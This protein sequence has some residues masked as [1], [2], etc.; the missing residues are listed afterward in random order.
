M[1]TAFPMKFGAELTDDGTRFRLWAPKADRVR[2]RLEGCSRDL[3]LKHLADGW[4]GLLFP[5]RVSGRLYSFVLPD[6]TEVPDPASRF[7]PQDLH[8]PSEVINPRDF[9]WTARSW[10]GVPWHDAVLYELH[11][12]TFTEEGTFAA[13][14][15]RLDYLRDLG[16]T[17]IELMPVADFPGRRNWGYDGALLFAPD[18]VYGRPEALKALVNEAHL[19]GLMVILDV[20]YNH[21][22]PDGNYLGLYAPFFN[23][24]HPTPWGGAIN[25]D[26]P[27][28]R[29]FMIA[30][31]LFWLTEYRFDGLRLDAVHAIHDES[32]EHILETM[33]K[34]IHQ[35]LPERQ[36]HLILENEENDSALLDRGADGKPLLYTAQWNDDV[37]HTLHTAVTDESGGYYADYAGD[38]TKLA[39]SLAEGFAFQGEMMDYR[40]A[41]RGKPAK[42]LPPTAFVA[43]IQNHDQVGNR[44]FGDRLSTLCA[45]APLRA[46]AAIYLL[47]PQIPMIFM[48]EE[49]GCRQPFPFFC[50]FAGELAEAVREG[51]RKEF[52]RFPDFR[53]EAQ[54]ERIPDPNALK[55][56]EAAKLDWNASR[57]P[58][59][60]HWH[61]FYRQ[62]LSVRRREIAPRLLGKL[63]S[64]SFDV[65]ANQALSVCWILGDGS[66]L[67]LDANLASEA[68]PSPANR[69]GRTIWSEGESDERLGPW[70]VVWTL[71]ADDASQ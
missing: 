52:A 21:F 29:E 25:Y 37:H 56:F 15:E 27:E 34:A 69:A 46:I 19:R 10:T 18:S 61:A 59:H 11:V 32:A 47:S 14:I 33:A 17:G 20:V 30:N 39:R 48:G 53:D 36:I 12:G 8:G 26:A 1:Q 60:S 54:R 2:L 63:K 23:E 68:A 50:D 9:H 22:G 55:T 28:V 44:A 66:K 43:F 71:D 4:H 51:R 40:E 41:P 31:A 24:A 62:L 16:V 5:E 70:S 38:T 35:S 7:Q 13:V 57:R 67:V 65:H 3:A 49:W 45:E 42:H 64:G 58:Q 6:G